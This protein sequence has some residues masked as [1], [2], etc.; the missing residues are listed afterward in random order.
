MLLHIIFLFLS[1]E[2]LS[3]VCLSVEVSQ[4]STVRYLG[5][6]QFLLRLNKGKNKQS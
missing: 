1:M 5:K 2:L 3:Q 4:H 6:S